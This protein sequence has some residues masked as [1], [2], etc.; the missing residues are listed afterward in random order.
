MCNKTNLL[1][2][3]NLFLFLGLLVFGT[4]CTEANELYRENQALTEKFSH[5]QEKAVEVEKQYPFDVRL[6]PI[7]TA[8]NKMCVECHKT[9]AP[10]LVM[11]WER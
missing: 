6:S 3:F 2:I 4:V 1:K 5:L 7:I 9:M 10:A 8:A 11:E